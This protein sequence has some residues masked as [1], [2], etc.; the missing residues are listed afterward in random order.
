MKMIKKFFNNCFFDEIKLF[1]L[2]ERHISI[3][4]IILLI[5]LFF[6]KKDEILNQI[7]Y[8]FLAAVIFYI[9]TVYI[10]KRK[11][12]KSFL[13]YIN[14]NTGKL[15]SYEINL[16]FEKVIKLNKLKINV[17]DL[18]KY[19]LEKK[20]KE[21]YSILDVLIIN[22]N[23]VKILLSKCEITYKE[24]V[25]YMDLCSDTIGKLTT[26]IEYL[27]QNTYFTKA[28]S[29]NRKNSFLYDIFYLSQ[30]VSLF[31]NHDIRDI[32][33]KKYHKEFKKRREFLK[34]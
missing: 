33:Q 34:Q 22:I 29:L 30:D 5:L 4:S 14:N 25:P 9:F 31:I 19:Y 11:K 15:F 18:E 8:S 6:I 26:I 2:S 21:L 28:N 32:I 13:L 17:S 24:L 16:F 20:F 10:P 7:I 23:D 27:K 1:W 3:I 12:M